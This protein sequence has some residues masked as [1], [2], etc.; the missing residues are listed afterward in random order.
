MAME[1]QS[2]T[3]A[4]LAERFRV[5]EPDAIRDLY[6][7]YG[8]S[9]YGV[10]YR[11]LGNRALAEEVVQ[12]TFLQAWR[13]AS[14]I[15]P[16]REIGPWLFTITR[17]VAIDVYRKESRRAHDAFDDVPENDPAVVTLGPAIEGMSDSWEV[18]VAVDALP[19]DERAIVRLQHFS[20]LTH[21]EIAQE[22]SVPVGTVKSRSFR[23]HRRLA[24]RLGHLEGAS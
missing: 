16:S 13:A 18:R 6:R 19:T 3:T 4:S 5:G 22:L 7:Q 20:G 17:R 2:T 9:V 12:Q 14:T 23:A 24:M 10:A 15:D 1:G 11:A 21:Q 8:R